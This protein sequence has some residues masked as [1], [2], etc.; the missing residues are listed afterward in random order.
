M[1]LLKDAEV[2][3][4]LGEKVGTLKRVVID[5]VDHEISHLVVAK[6]ILFPED[7]VIPI[8]W[9]ET[10]VRERIRLKETREQLNELPDFEESH[11]VRLNDEEH[12][13]D[14]EANYWYPPVYTWWRASGSIDSTMP[15]YVLKTEQNIPK[16]TTAL[17]EGAMVISK[18]DEHVGNIETILI[19]P[20]D[21]RATHFVVSKGLLLK[22]RKLV[23]TFWIKDLQENR[24]LLHIKAHVFE[25]LPNYHPEM[26]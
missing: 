22:E 8:E 11:Y 20:E 6:G 23:P 24:V 13:H 9:I 3:S 16:G 15:P 17:K 14:V 7:K 25:R 2:F 4:S 5:P 1:R 18:D 19:D 10:E 12:D 26:T 21:H